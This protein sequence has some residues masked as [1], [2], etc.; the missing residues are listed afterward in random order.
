MTQP[1]PAQTSGSADAADLTVLRLGLLA[2]L[3]G[4]LAQTLA[5]PDLWGHV[6][7]GLDILASGIPQLDPYSFTSDILWVNHEWL[8]EVLMALAWEAAAGPG[9]I[10]LKTFVIAI[11]AASVIAVLR[12]DKVGLPALDLLTAVA[13]L[14]LW[15]R[16]FVIRPQIFSLALFA[17]LLL[18]LRRAERGRPQ[19][20]WLLPP[21]FALW[22]NLHGGWLVGIAALGCWTAATLLL[23]G[24]L[25]RRTVLLA[26]AASLAATLANPYGIG[27]LGFMHG[28][29]GLSRPDINDWR[30]MLDMSAAEIV[31]WL[32]SLGVTVV[33]LIRSRL[34]V[35]PAHLLIVVG[36]AGGSFQVNRLDAFFAMSTVMLLGRYAA[37][38]TAAPESVGHWTSRATAVASVVVL[39]LMLG[40]WAARDRLSCISLA[41]PWMP[42][43][44]AGALVASEA[45]RGRLLSYFDW[46]Q[47]AIWH[48]AP[49]LTVST[50]GRRETVYSG[51]LL[52]RHLAL[53]TDPSD[54]AFL[55]RLDPDYAWLP[56]SLP[57][58]RFLENRGW[59]KLFDG[60]TSVVLARRPEPMADSP[61]LA[62]RACFPGP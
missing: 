61:Q 60:P 46:G 16:V 29:V 59:H 43:R 33:A 6:R 18:V 50:D 5:D 56:A 15:P 26:S 49:R 28:T 53:Y 30:P 1:R 20:L 62:A 38:P 14:G 39:V 58:T 47:Y 25:Q 55:D 52:A 37:A 4:G 35:P 17:L 9:L 22:V 23:P 32:I 12:S 40:A 24:P 44:A 7:F 54:Q 21:L 19:A 11:V 51:Q 42:E 36:L 34:R 48:A 45:M 31:P 10:G 13:L 41:G 2:A 3:L 27:M 57:L 8:A